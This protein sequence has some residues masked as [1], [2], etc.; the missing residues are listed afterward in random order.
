MDLDAFV[1]EHSA[2]WRRLEWLATHRRKLSAEQADELVVLYQ[3]AATHLSLIRSRSP[4]PA[5]VA[6]LSRLV[7]S[8]R[9]A[10]TG[11]PARFWPAVVRFWTESFP[12]A[13]YRA[14]PWWAGVGGA[15][16]AVTAWLMAHYATHPDDVAQFISSSDAASLVNTEFEAYYHQSLPENFAFAVWTNNARVTA[17]CLASGVVILPVLLVLFDNMLNLGLTGGVMIA[18]G[19]SDTFFGLLLVHGMLELT[20]VF[21]AAGVGLRIGWAWIAPGPYRSRGQAL[22]ESGRAGMVI[23]LGL[24][25]V[26]LVSGAIE[27]FVT[28]FVPTAV[29]LVIGG[30]AWLGFLAYVVLFGGR[31]VRSGVTGDLAAEDREALVPTV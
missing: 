1:A 7:L 4:D 15:C 20:C 5:L 16:I 8:A 29:A 23:A 17:V 6:R 2:E 22:A 28:P 27:A 11:T 3:R 26:L 30:V 24:A 19:K 31:A 18:Y 12:A 14:W 21:V 25:G 9:G 13:T 10:L